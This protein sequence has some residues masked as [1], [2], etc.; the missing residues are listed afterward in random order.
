MVHLV[1]MNWTD[2]KPGEQVEVWAYSNADTVE[3]QLNGK[4][5]GV[6]RFDRKTTTYG[7]GYLETTEATGDDKTFPSG[8][9][10]SPNGST[11]K[12]HLTWKVPFERGTLVA[13]A[14]R[15]G[16]EVARDRLD[17]AGAPHAIKLTP[18]REKVTADGRSLAFVTAEVVDRD[19][20][21]VPGA[22][23]PVTVRVGRGELAGLD[24]GREES[25]E[26]YRARTRMTFNGK[27]L[28]VVR[29][30]NRPGAITVTA[31]APGLR[32]GTA[33]I[34]STAAHG[35]VTPA[36]DPVVR[37]WTPPAAAP[38][39]ASYSGSAATI[40]AAMLD[41]DLTTAWSNFYVKE[42]TALLPAISAAH[43]TEWVSV[44]S[45]K[46][47]RIT[48]PVQAFFTTGAGRVLPSA[49]T[50][51]YWDGH[52]YTPVRNLHVTWATASNQPT[53]IT[54]DPV[55]TTSLR[56]DLTSPASGTPNGFL[57]IAE[58]RVP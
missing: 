49:M 57:Q 45:P 9:Y 54:F 4:S 15:N 44:E 33:T 17:T 6:R 5:L 22:A 36:A 31:T 52:R 27:A 21:V 48:G 2:H 1:P 43:A 11:G 19:G 14:K 46:P 47:R 16:R 20:V 41:G 58:L 29:A 51:S 24:S 13:V 7:T 30:A 23:V 26:N 18:D 56:F 12:L 39:D 35:Q 25:A 34:S 40:P 53:T 55:T 37:D 28:A 50:V 3:L 42:A 38:A 10:T 32:T 8:S